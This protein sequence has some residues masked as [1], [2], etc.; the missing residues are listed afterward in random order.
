MVI[1]SG[2]GL[3]YY[4]RIVY[5]MLTPLEQDLVLPEAGLKELLS[6]CLLFILLLLL[7]VLGIVPGALMQWLEMMAS[8]L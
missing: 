4:L 7:L 8:A 3:F 5:G 1:G 6:H 2:I